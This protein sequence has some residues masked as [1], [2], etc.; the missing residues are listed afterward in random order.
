M[1]GR[2]GPGAQHD[3]QDEA[4]ITSTVIA[5]LRGRLRRLRRLRMLDDP[6]LRCELRRLEEE[7]VIWNEDTAPNPGRHRAGGAPGSRAGRPAGESGGPGLKPDPASA[8]TAAE[9]VEMLRRYVAWSG[10]SLRKVAA[11]GGQSRVASTLCTAL[12]REVLPT[13]EVVEAVLI[14]CGG[15]Q[16]DLQAF[17]AAWQRISAASGPGQAEGADLLAAPVLAP[18]LVPSR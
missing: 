7:L 13:R 5:G 18:R 1:S 8:R 6:V 10:L 12:N 11:R 2:P 3:P 16:D 4:V 14:G 9:L 17:T 15:S